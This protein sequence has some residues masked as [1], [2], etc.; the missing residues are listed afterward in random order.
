MNNTKY[1]GN[2]RYKVH[3][4]TYGWQEWKE[5][6]AVAGTTGQAKRLEAIRIELTGQM[7]EKYDVYYRGHSQTYGWLGWAKNGEPAGTEGLAKRLEALQ[8]VLIPKGGEAPGSTEN[9]IVKN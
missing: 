4:Q 8:I 6:G 5:G 7:A 2:L 9:S 1:S 3:V